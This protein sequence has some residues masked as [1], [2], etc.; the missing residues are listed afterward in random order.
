MRVVWCSHS[1]GGAVSG[2]GA[3]LSALQ[4]SPQ[5]FR[6]AGRTWAWLPGAAGLLMPPVLQL[7]GRFAA[8]IELAGPSWKVLIHAL[9]CLFA[10]RHFRL[11]VVG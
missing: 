10:Y 5:I 7:A 1:T 6:E 8:R 2:Q 9:T 3:V 4:A 11:F